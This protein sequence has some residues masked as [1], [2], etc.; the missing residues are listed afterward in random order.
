[1]K[2]SKIAVAM[3]AVF[4]AVSF[5]KAEAGTMEN[6]SGA[7]DKIASVDM[8][9]DFGQAGSILDSFFSGSAAKKGS[10]PVEASVSGTAAAK[11]GTAVNAY[12]QS[13]KDLYN[14]QPS[15]MGK[16]ASAVKPLAGSS[17]KAGAA[18][19]QKGTSWLDDFNTVV[20][21]VGNVGGAA[22]DVAEDLYNTN[23][24]DYTH[25]DNNITTLPGHVVDLYEAITCTD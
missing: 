6:L 18:G 19:F 11:A 13:A 1:M 24:G 20:D 16:L 22:L 3:I 10:A 12:G 8:K 15:K 7:G 25:P 14:A 2:M 23:N 21:Y 17:A 5:A 9:K 4:A